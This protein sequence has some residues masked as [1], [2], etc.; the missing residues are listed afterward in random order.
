MEDIKELLLGSKVF[1]KSTVEMDS[2][3]ETETTETEE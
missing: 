2:Q 3:E 1:D